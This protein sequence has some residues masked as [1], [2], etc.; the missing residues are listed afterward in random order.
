MGCTFAARRG[1]RPMATPAGT[2]QRRDKTSAAT[3]LANVASAE[4]ASVSHCW[5]EIASTRWAD[6][7]ALYAT[8]TTAESVK[9]VGRSEARAERRETT[10]R[11]MAPK[12][13]WKSEGEWSVL[14]DCGEELC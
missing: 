4:V 12:R 2:V 14:T 3:T 10:V 9:R 13:D 1:L 5:E 8:A 11:E 6:Y 7:Q